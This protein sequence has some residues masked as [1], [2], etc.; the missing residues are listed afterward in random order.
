[1]L[2]RYLL[3]LTLASAASAQWT[4]HIIANN[5]RTST[6]VAADFTGDGRVDVIAN[7][8]DR[9]ED[10]L[11]TAPDFK[12]TVLHEGYSPIHSAVIRV[13]GKPVYVA[14][15]YSPGIIYSIDPRSKAM[16][17]LTRELNGIHGLMVGDVDGDGKPDIAANSAEPKGKHAQSIAWLKAPDWTVQIAG[18]HDAPGLSHYLGIGDVN[19]DGRADLASAAKVGNWFAVW[20][21][22]PSKWTK[23]V[24]ADHQDGAT[25]LLP[26]DVNRDRKMDLIASR[27]H[28][29][30]LLWFEGPT[31][32]PHVIDDA[33]EFPHSV[34]IGDID[35]DGD[36]DVI[37]C[38]A[39]Y[40]ETPAKTRLLAWF[41]NDGK[42]RFRPHRIH[43]DQASYHISLVDM[44][45]DRDLDVLVAGQESR[46]VVWYENK[47]ARSR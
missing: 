47:M 11:F 37:A 45:G 20:L 46:N 41:E 42:G 12:P 33:I 25:H 44:D 6:A 39:F 29:K 5:Y 35:G 16:R 9:K 36:V 31:W 22:G 43:E 1:M 10:V 21:Q 18:D 4:Q 38:T 2:M 17:V 27:G 7:E 3:A 14:A 32:Q 40:S 28:G 23:Q 30:G 13:D 26:A 34:D 19:G 8:S 24:I 15:Q